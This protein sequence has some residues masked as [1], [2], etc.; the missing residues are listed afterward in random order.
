[1]LYWIYLLGVTFL[2]W[3]LKSDIIGLK[4]MWMFKMLYD[5]LSKYFL[6]KF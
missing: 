6:G 3:I 4:E 1:M 2:G 5:M